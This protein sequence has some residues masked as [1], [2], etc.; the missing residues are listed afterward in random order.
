MTT[1]TERHPA[2]GVLE[3]APALVSTETPRVYELTGF[4]SVEDFLRGYEGFTGLRAPKPA[5]QY[6]GFVLL[7]SRSRRDALADLVAAG[8]KRLR[9]PKFIRD[10]LADE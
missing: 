2:A 1:S 9:S 4:K 7:G 8:V 3:S 10:L 6:T 5:D